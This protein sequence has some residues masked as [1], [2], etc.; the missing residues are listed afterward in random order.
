MLHDLYCESFNIMLN[1]SP[2]VHNISC[3]T[4]QA[5]A[6]WLRNCN[7]NQSKQKLSKFFYTVQTDIK[8]GFKCVDC[9]RLYEYSL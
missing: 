1:E 2:L 8:T 9:F 5:V 6:P 7:V 3:G 4:R